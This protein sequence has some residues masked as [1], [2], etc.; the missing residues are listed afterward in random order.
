MPFWRRPLLVFGAPARDGVR[1]LCGFVDIAGPPLDPL[2]AI[3]HVVY[4]GFDE[5]RPER[6][7]RA[8]VL[9]HSAGGGGGDKENSHG[10]WNA[11]RHGRQARELAS[12]IPARRG[13]RRRLR[14][15][16]TA[17]QGGRKGRAAAGA[18]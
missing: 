3:R 5:W 18:K 10:Q 11:Q 14:D 15:G 13:Y 7:E 9:S 2:P 16:V 17:R 12:S 1:A 6:I 8:D 4:T